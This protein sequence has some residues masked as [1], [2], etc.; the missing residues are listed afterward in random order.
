MLDW[1]R[2]MEALLRSVSIHSP[3]QMQSSFVISLISLRDSSSHWQESPRWR[4][5]D[6][7]GAALPCTQHIQPE[8]CTK[9]TTALM[10]CQRGASNANPRAGSIQ[11]YSFIMPCDRVSHRAAGER[12]KW[13]DKMRLS[14]DRWCQR[15]IKHKQTENVLT[16]LAE[17]RRGATHGERQTHY[18]CSHEWLQRGIK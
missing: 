12:F 13:H 18:F 10:L 6:E 5:S 14:I 7:T 3:L 4:S 8:W 2:V 15:A 1:N 11:I 9:L 16:Q 17:A